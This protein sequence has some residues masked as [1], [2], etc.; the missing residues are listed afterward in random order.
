[1]SPAQTLTLE[2]KLEHHEIELSAKA[3]PRRSR[4]STN[5]GVASD[6]RCKAS[7]VVPF[8]WVLRWLL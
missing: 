8:A 6:S 5:A 2:E 3:S 7:S 4:D 1:M